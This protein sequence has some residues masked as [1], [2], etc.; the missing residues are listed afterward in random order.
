MKYLWFKRLGWSYRPVSWQGVVLV[1]IA[2]L[3]CWQVFRA[4]DG[5][6]HSASDT[7]FGVFPYFASC[8]LLLNWVAA[9]TSDKE[10]WY[11]GRTLD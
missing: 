7:L 6:S 3:F 5:H 9:N 11:G 1:L 8:F 4:I 2:I 10:K